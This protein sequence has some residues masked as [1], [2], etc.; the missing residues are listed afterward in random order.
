M[1]VCVIIRGVRDAWS[2]VCLS[3]A[4]HTH[5]PRVR[6]RVE[7][8]WECIAAVVC[9]TCLPPL[10]SL[11]YIQMVIVLEGIAVGILDGY[12]IIVGARQRA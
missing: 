11:A 5:A 7:L 12:P 10:Q 6:I 9:F 2:K 8:E 4:A 1:N 3:V